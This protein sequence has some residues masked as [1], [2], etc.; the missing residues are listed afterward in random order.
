MSIE[1]GQVY[2]RRTA[3]V[4]IVEKRTTAPKDWV[5][6]VDQKIEHLKWWDVLYLVDD[7]DFPSYKSGHVSSWEASMLTD[8][9]VQRLT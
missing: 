2:Q 6:V 4:L 1:V 3:I 7:E 8:E 5:S 9:H